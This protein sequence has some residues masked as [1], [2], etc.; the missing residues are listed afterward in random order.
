MAELN[1]KAEDKNL[2]QVLEFVDCEL[3]KADCPMKTQLQI[4]VAVEELFINIAHYAYDP[5]VGP[6]TIQVEVIEN[7]LSVVLTFIDE[8]IPYDP[9][10]KQDPD[11]TL[12]AEEREIGGLGIFMV[13]KSMDAIHYEYKDG[14]N[15][16][17]IKKSL[18]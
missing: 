14:K 15:V 8:G 5:K 10:K 3:E 13:K 7:P 12:S 2:D 11:V 18:E 1:I 9:L 4:D 17:T 16:L 6:A